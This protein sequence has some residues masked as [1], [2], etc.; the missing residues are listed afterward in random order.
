MSKIGVTL[1]LFWA[2][3]LALTLA[4]PFSAHAAAPAQEDAAESAGVYRT[5]PMEN[6]ITGDT[7]ERSITLFE[8]GLAESETHFANTGSILYEAGDWQVDDEG[9]ILVVLYDSYDFRNGRMRAV[10]PPTEIPFELAD[11]SLIARDYLFYGPRDLILALTDEEPVS[12][13]DEEGALRA[14]LIVETEEYPST[15]FVGEY[16]TQEFEIEGDSAWL[17]LA[18]AEDGSARVQYSPIPGEVI[19][20]SLGIWYNNGNG[21]I[22]ISVVEDLDAA[23]ETLETYDP[24]LDLFELDRMASGALSARKPILPDGGQLIFSDAKYYVEPDPAAVTGLYAGA[25]ADG[26]GIVTGRLLYLYED[27]NARLAVS[28]FA[29]DAPPQTLIGVWGVEVGG[30]WLEIVGEIVHE[31]GE[32]AVVDLEEVVAYAFALEGGTL[33]GDGLRFGRVEVADEAGAAPAGAPSGETGGETASDEGPIPVE[34]STWMVSR[35]QLVAGNTVVLSLRGDR[36]ASIS[37]QL[38]AG[39]EQLLELGTWENAEGLVV[40]TLTQALSGSNFEE[41]DEARVLTFEQTASNT[42]TALEYDADI[43]GEELVLFDTR[44]Y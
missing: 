38:G 24:P 27:G 34:D 6:E 25:S 39:A 44:D 7:I 29:G 41:Y 11:D 9:R 21:S 16:R 40:V 18:L 8:D 19:D 43:Y 35:E 22:S 42:L 30:V 31:E 5:E 33:A 13:L 3:A 4:T 10:E 14:D 17:G 37:T 1:R 12:F 28:T 20:S 2:A 23:G 26:D 36:S 32:A 15:V